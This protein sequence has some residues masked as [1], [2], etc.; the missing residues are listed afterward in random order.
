MVRRRRGPA[1]ERPLPRGFAS[2]RTVDEKALIKVATAV[3]PGMTLSQLDEAVALNRPL[4]HV[5][6]LTLLWSGRC[7][8][9]FSTPAQPA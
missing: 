1:A 6:V 8:V 9:D 3:E 7:A 5:A 2:P 4:A